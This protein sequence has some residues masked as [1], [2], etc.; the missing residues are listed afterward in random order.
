MR[1][2]G[3]ISWGDVPT[4][5]AAILTSGSVYAAFLTLRHNGRRQIRALA[6]AVNISS[7]R[8]STRANRSQ[9]G[10]EQGDTRGPVDKQVSEI[11]PTEDASDGADEDE[12]DE[13]KSDHRGPA[14]DG[15]PVLTN[16]GELPI[17]HVVLIVPSS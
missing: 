13:G 6:R 11:V 3:G 7:Y 5:V 14:P 9:T 8:V 2:A 1:M 17:S 12:K 10:S 16:N 4:W 15:Q